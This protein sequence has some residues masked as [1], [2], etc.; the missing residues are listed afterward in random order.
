VHFDVADLIAMVQEAMLKRGANLS[1]IA[2]GQWVWVAD[3][4]G[5]PELYVILPGIQS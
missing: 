5:S 1:T 2:A 3:R 4:N